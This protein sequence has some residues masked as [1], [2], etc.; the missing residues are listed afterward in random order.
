MGWMIFL[1]VG[2]MN[3]MIRVQYS[4]GEYDYVRPEILDKK[5]TTGEIKKFSRSTGWVVVGRDPIR[6]NAQIGGIISVRKGDTLPI[7]LS[8][9]C[10]ITRNA[11]VRFAIR[12]PPKQ[13]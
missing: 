3:M 7:K 1:N 8:A 4:G 13:N 10:P 2:G 11:T 6:E 9:Y 12:R 5:L